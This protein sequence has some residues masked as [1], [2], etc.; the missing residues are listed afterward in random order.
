MRRKDLA[1]SGSLQIENE[2]GSNLLD[3]T[4]RSEQPPKLLE[5]LSLRH[6]SLLPLIPLHS[7]KPA[8]RLRATKNCDGMYQISGYLDSLY[9]SDTVTRDKL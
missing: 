2:I 3:P 4:V 7:E 1:H 5:L 6:H 8:P 9:A